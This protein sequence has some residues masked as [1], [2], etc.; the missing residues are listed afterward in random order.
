M[1]VCEEVSRLHS[2]GP[3]LKVPRL[4]TD[5]DEISTVSTVTETRSPEKIYLLQVITDE[6]ID[7]V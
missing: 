1:Y 7:F 4:N 5:I 6:M 2:Y 3:N